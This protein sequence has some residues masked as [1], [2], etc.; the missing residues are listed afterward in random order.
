VRVHDNAVE[1]LLS[2]FTSSDRAEAIAGDLMEER[3]KHGSAWF[4]RHV[5][6]TMLA[7]WRSA[8]M[9][10]PLRVIMLAMAGCALFTAPAFG[11]V[12]ALR[13]FPQW[14]GSPV[15]W[16]ALSLFWWGGALWTGASL[17]GIAPQ[18][19]MAACATLAVAGEAL[20]IGLGV[21]VWRG[22]LETDFV[23]FYTTGL[24]VTAPLL[25]GGAIA[26]GRM[27][28]SGIRALEQGR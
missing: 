23:L 28:A 11:G 8:L 16:I 7:L 24:L 20:L 3:E 17:V 26:R 15:S 5:A 6:G 14:T 22:P 9:D 4:W 2:L 13:L 12:A 1:G 18:R 25:V 19:G 10:G 21:T 27:I